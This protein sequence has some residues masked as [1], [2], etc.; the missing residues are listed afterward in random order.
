M[1]KQLIS[2]AHARWNWIILLSANCCFSQ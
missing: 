1:R 2:F